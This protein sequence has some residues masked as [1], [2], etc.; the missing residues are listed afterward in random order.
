MLN[1]HQHPESQHPDESI[2]EINA[3]WDA[4]LRRF[5]INMYPVFEKYG[6]SLP[7]AFLVS[8]LN[9]LQN[10][11]EEMNRGNEEE[12]EPWKKPKS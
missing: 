4:A 6:F 7:E 9:Q 12:E 5:Q 2:N 11:V 3:S 1:D 10:E 8:K